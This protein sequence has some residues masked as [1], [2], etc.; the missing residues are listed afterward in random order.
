[1]TEGYIK[2]HRN[3]LENPVTSKP[4]FAWLWCVLLLSANHKDKKMIWNNQNLIIKEGQFITGR[5]ALSKKTGLSEN[6]IY[7]ALKYFESE[8][9]IKQQKNN[10]FTIIT[11]L[12]WHKYQGNGTTN[13]QQNEQ[14]IDNK[15]TTSEQP[16]DTNKNEKNEKKKELNTFGIDVCLQ[17]STP[18]KID[19]PLPDK[20]PDKPKPKKQTDDRNKRIYFDR[21]QGKFIGITQKDLDLWEKAFPAVDLTIEVSKAIVWIYSAG[22]KGYKTKWYTFLNG[23]FNRCQNS[24]GTKNGRV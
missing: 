12:N 23:W 14:E 22:A 1:M 18:E 10:K 24:G 17:T 7:R 3:L 2:L 8:H 9:Q 20:E 11:I 21:E 19:T 15:S 4:E 5:K 16:V 13:E 6:K